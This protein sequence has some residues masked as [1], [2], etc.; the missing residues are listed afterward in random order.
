[1]NIRLWQA[2][3]VAMIWCV[4]AQAKPPSAPGQGS[5]AGQTKQGQSSSG[6]QQGQQSQPSSQPPANQPTAEERSAL[7]TIQNELDPDRQIQMVN[8]F[9]KKYPN[10]VLMTTAY[11][12]AANAYQQKSDPARVI[13]YGEKSLKLNADNIATLLLLS[14]LLPQPQ[15]L[16][17]ASDVERE[18]RLTDADSYAHRSLQLLETLP[19]GVNETDEGFKKRKGT[20]EAQ[21][22]AALGMIHLQRS[23]ESLGPPDKEELKKAE[24]EY[25]AAVS[26]APRPEAQDY[27]RLGEVYKRESK[28]DDAIDAFSKA[29]ELGR[30]TALQQYADQ[31][32]AELKKQAQAK[33]PANH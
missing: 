7:G 11:F 32:V 33:P 28:I 20:Y 22:H 4:G 12:L 24:E 30:G 29:S 13:E 31:Q 26:M 27:Y 8:D 14:S 5:Q 25:K 1:M 9:E 6:G 17:G 23:T 19:K 2:L 16:Q 21:P 3:I 15:Y 18:K 10:S